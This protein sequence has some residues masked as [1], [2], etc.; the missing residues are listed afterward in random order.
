MER[1]DGVPSMSVAD[2]RPLSFS[3]TGKTRPIVLSVVI[4]FPNNN[5]PF[6]DNKAR[7]R[8]RR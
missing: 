6:L 3:I 1:C 5:S 4:T 2:L 7:K 8:T